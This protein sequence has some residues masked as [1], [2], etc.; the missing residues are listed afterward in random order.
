MGIATWG[1]YFTNNVYEVNNKKKTKKI[2]KSI[3][4]LLT[5]GTP[6]LMIGKDTGKK[7]TRG[8]E[9]LDSFNELL[10][11][12]TGDNDYYYFS[13]QEWGIT[14]E[15]IAKENGIENKVSEIINAFSAKIKVGDEEVDAEAA[16][17][18]IIEW[19]NDQYR[20]DKGALAST[21][22][23]VLPFTAVVTAYAEDMFFDDDGLL[24]F[25]NDNDKKAINQVEVTHRLGMM[26]KYKTELFLLMVQRLTTEGSEERKELLKMIKAPT[27]EP[28]GIKTWS[29][30]PNIKYWANT[31]IG[32]TWVNVRSQKRTLRRVYCNYAKQ[33]GVPEDRIEKE[34]ERKIRVIT[35]HV[36]GVNFI[37]QSL[38]GS[39]REILDD[40]VAANY[41]ENAFIVRRKQRNKDNEIVVQLDLADKA[42]EAF[43][44][45]SIAGRI[46]KED[47][48][49][50]IRKKAQK[51][52]KDIIENETLAPIG[53]EQKA[54]IDAAVKAAE[55]DIETTIENAVEAAAQAILLITKKADKA[56]KKSID[57]QIRQDVTDAIVSKLEKD[58]KSEIYNDIKKQIDALKLR[59]AG[60]KGRKVSNEITH[61]V[62]ENMKIMLEL[63]LHRNSQLEEA[64]RK[65]R[66]KYEDMKKAELLENGFKDLYRKMELSKA[67]KGILVPMLEMIIQERVFIASPKGGGFDVENYHGSKWNQKTAVVP[68]AL[69]PVLLNLD[70]DH[71]ALFSG[72]ESVVSHLL[73]YY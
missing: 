3:K 31:Q 2:I 46:H 13:S 22:D 52:A 70:A 9:R 69:G 48:I 45:G 15:D 72:Q 43:D 42:L 51:I 19:I 29:I 59:M 34:V 55:G 39:L 44:A 28:K 24:K 60:D 64:A 25:N 62:S 14:A 71:R 11:E 50:R 7:K 37:D 5:D 36:Q 73:E 38:D 10:D 66:Q 63:E 26:A 33:L 57:K 47:I 49:E 1:Y 58:K 56:D 67:A 8:Q 32:T 61:L 27:Y 40:I 54:A 30:W 65:L 21:W 53:A 68:Y 16:L 35:R 18:R 20:R 41:D 12:M 6:G 4:S 23:E 17:L